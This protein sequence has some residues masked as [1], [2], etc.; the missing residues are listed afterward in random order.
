MGA[1]L[2][3][4]APLQSTYPPEDAAWV[5]CVVWGDVSPPEVKYFS[6]DSNWDLYV[7]DKS[8]VLDYNATLEICP[9]EGDHSDE[10]EVEILL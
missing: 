5:F 6:I 7:S 4:V 1:A 2:H 8:D 3:D 10:D 9:A